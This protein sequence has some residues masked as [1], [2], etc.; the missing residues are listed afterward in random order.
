MGITG[1]KQKDF[2]SEIALGNVTGKSIVNKFGHAPSGIQTTDSDLWARSDATPTQQVYV[3]PTE[4]RTHTLVSSSA[5]D[6]SAVATLTLT[7]NA[8]NTETVTIGSKVYTFEDTLTD[9]DGNVKVGASASASI[10][11]LVAAINLAAGAGSTY[12]TSMT[13]NSDLTVAAVGAGDTMSLY[14]QTAGAI[15]TTETFGSGAWGAGNAV[16]GVGARTVSISGL[17][18]W[19]SAETSETIILHGVDGVET[20]GTY[21]FINRM[22]VLTNG[23]TSKN[24]GALTLTANT[25]SSI[26]AVILAD[27]GQT[28]Q[29]IMGFPSIQTAL[30]S[31]YYATLNKAQGAAATVNL[32]LLVNTTP[33]SELTKFTLKHEQGMQSTGSS[34]FAHTFPCPLKISGPAIIKLTGFGSAADLDV[35]G[36]FDV[37]LSTN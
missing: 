15:A 36:G 9:V 7:G 31:Q 37:V 24:V 4:A 16:V 26:S 27:E 19:A 33:D 13:A 3:A 6:N 14:V 32:K 34:H 10:D 1:S 18:T 20:E 21:V 11:N 25:D 22:E 30:I 5:S 28:E 12:A 23:A 8:A 17:A 29:A 2:A 35:T